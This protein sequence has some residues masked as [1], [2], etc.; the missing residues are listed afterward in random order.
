MRSR[1]L[2]ALIASLITGAAFAANLAFLRDAPITRLSEGE[3]AT[4]KAFVMKTLDEKPDGQTVEWT[5]PKTRFTSR[6]TLDK[7]FTD[8]GRRCRTVTVN[9]KAHDLQMR[10]SYMLCKVSNEDW[11]FRLRG[12]Q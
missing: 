8:S 2:V 9:S 11:E 6:I 5:A 4:F 7:S 3:L 12:G 1:I 10:G